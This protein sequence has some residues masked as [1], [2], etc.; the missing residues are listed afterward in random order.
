MTETQ[1]SPTIRITDE[2]TKS[3]IAEA[4]GYANHTAKREM[5]VVGTPTAPTPWDQRH[6]LIDSLLYDWQRAPA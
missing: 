5:P 2:S 4:L 3:E 6:K 1:P